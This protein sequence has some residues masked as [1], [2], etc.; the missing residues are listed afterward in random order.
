MQNVSASH[1]TLLALWIEDNELKSWC[2]EFP[3]WWQHFTHKT[4]AVIKNL[5]QVLETSIHV[6]F[7]TIKLLILSSSL[8]TKDCVGSLYR[9]QTFSVQ[10]QRE[11]D[12]GANP[13]TFW[14]R[15]GIF[16]PT[17]F[18]KNYHLKMCVALEGKQHVGS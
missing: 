5:I 2:T 17:F 4:F 13:G 6:H 15:A 16:F 3:R 11:L 10:N 7:P 9:L 1:L 12:M 8:L 14:E 18:F